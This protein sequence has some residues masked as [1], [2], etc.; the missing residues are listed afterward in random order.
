LGFYF[1]VRDEGDVG[2]GDTIEL[3]DSDDKSVTIAEFV[4]TYLNYM[5]EPE[6]LTRILASRS[7]SYSWRGYL[8]EALRK[9]EPGIGSTGWTGFRPFLVDRKVVESEDITSFHLVPVGRQTTASLQARSVP[10]V[11][12]QHPGSCKARHTHLLAFQQPAFRPL[13]HHRKA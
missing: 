2:A 13:S 6:R 5:H 3:I 12:A 10:H 8:E 9:A 11:H 1:R 7:L 4:E